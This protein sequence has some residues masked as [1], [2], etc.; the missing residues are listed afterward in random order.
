[1]S[2]VRIGVYFDRAHMTGSEW[3]MLQSVMAT[4]GLRLAVVVEASGRDAAP[5]TERP[6]AI[7]ALRA[8]AWKAANWSDQLLSTSLRKSNA[9]HL[10]Y[11][12]DARHGL[13]KIPP[14]IPRTE[15]DVAAESL[16]AADQAD[17]LQRIAACDLD[18]LVC[19]GRIAPARPLARFSRFGLWGFLHS[20]GVTERGRPP[21]FW[22]WYRKTGDTGTRLC[23]WSDGSDDGATIAAASYRTNFISWNENRRRVVAASTIMLL[24]ALAQLRDRGE[25]PEARCQPFGPSDQQADA[26]PHPIV[27]LAALAKLAARWLLYVADRLFVREQWRLL[28]HEGPSDGV[29]LQHFDALTPPPDRFWADPFVLSR[30]GRNFVLFEDYSF[31]SRLGKISAI[32]FKDGKV[33]DYGT[34]LEPPHHLSFPFLFEF[35]NELYMIPESNNA[36]TVEIWKCQEAP[37]RW[38][39]FRTIMTG[40]RA[41]DTVLF[42]HD[43][44]WWLFTRIRRINQ[45][46]TSE[47]HLFYSD[48]P[49]SQDWQPHPLNPVCRDAKTGRM[50]GKILRSRDG[51][52]VRCAQSNCHRYGYSIVFCEIRTLT[53]DDYEE[54]IVSEIKPRWAPGLI[55]THHYDSDGRLTA[56]DAC[57][58]RLKRPF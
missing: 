26:P 16:A 34:V 21:G 28:V 14:D 33:V 2:D 37:Y 29:P 32:E 39:K 42:P 4:D 27:S 38:E 55:G 52:I 7:G 35:E 15:I 45:Q 18:V 41:C 40:V 8:V 43:G 50:G 51:K 36:S 44:T 31:R 19:F 13:E 22:E 11:S 53:R 56:V 25:V 47:L 1:M 12:V 20:N 49:F 24:D 46:N 17:V 57:F 48:H 9:R 6:A 5:V 58:R 10:K 3:Q 54:R 30:E 23:R